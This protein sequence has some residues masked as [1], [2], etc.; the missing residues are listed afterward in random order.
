MPPRTILYT[1]KGGVGKTSIAAATGRSCAAAGMRTLLL[2]IDPAHGLDGCLEA[3]VGGQ[4][5]AVADHLWAQQLDA[6]TG[7]EHGWAALRALIAGADAGGSIR[8]EELTVAPGL[9]AL[10]GLLELKR[11]YEDDRFDVVIVD[12]APTGET[13]RLLS[14]PDVA[15]WWLDKLPLARAVLGVSGDGVVAA[16]Q[17]LVR[18]VVAMNEVLRDTERVSLRLVTTPDRLVI[19]EARRTFTYFNLYGFLTDAVVVNRLFPAEVGDYFAAWRDRQWAQLLA[20]RD[21]FAPIPVLCAPFFAEELAGP[22]ALDALAAAV[23]DGLGA[24]DVLHSAPSQELV[25]GPEG[26][27]LRLDLPFAE[28]AD[29]ELKKIG[30]ELVVRV[31]GRKRTLLLPPALDDYRPSGAS[32]QDGVLQVSFAAK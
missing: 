22:A 14:F 24:A 4:P 1:G 15:R 19:D 31:E 10:F 23:F 7:L 25:V 8:G 2:S 21:M 30:L 32:F 16:L 27:T 20:A 26:A 28:K 5:T 18:D 9:D 13:L 3:Q 11:H 6:Q 29:I 17:R 12:C